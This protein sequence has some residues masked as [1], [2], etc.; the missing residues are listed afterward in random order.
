LTGTELQS[1]LQDEAGRHLMRG[2]PKP[3]PVNPQVLGAYAGKYQFSNDV[4]MTV[5]VDGTRIFIQAPD[6]PEYES[7]ALSENQF[8]PFVFE[9]EFTFYKNTSG[10]VDPCHF[11][12]RLTTRWSRPGQLRRNWFMLVS[13][14][15]PGGSSR[16]R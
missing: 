3:F 12:G 15:W 5:R 2:L 13:K 7:F 11:F 4:A 6:Q 10:E 8:H 1:A 9:A 16:G 14:S